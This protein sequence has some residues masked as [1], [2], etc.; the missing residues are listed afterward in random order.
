MAKSS[1]KKNRLGFIVGLITVI[2]AVV[3]IASTADRVISK[4]KNF[5][6]KAAA[7]AEYEEFL[8]PFVMFDPDPFD[9]IS[10]A[11]IAQ[12]INAAIWSVTS[13][14]DSSD[15]YEYTDGGLLIPAQ[16][17]TEEFTRLF[18]SQIEDLE[19]VYRTVDM[20]AHDITYDSAQAGF[21]I[22]ITSI[23]IAYIPEVYEIET[24]GNSIILSVGY[25]GAK[26]WAQVKD[27]EYSAAEPD[28]YMQITLREQD[29]GGYYIASVQSGDSQ[30]VAAITVTAPVTSTEKVT[31]PVTESTS[32][33]DESQTAEDEESISETQEDSQEEF[34]ES[35]D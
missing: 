13:D 29:N 7:K 6:S 28:K 24:K 14:D 2:F 34:S 35:E 11:K 1:S 26:S 4:V 3:G 33:E 23:D 21:I 22:P 19:S 9:D 31:A 8:E 27:G 25:I 32:A 20:S 17:V 5:D 15:M 30:Q 16:A 10:T 18:G 12:L